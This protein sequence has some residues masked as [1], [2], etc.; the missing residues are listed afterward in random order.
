LTP[1]H[2]ASQLPRLGAYLMVL[3][4]MLRLWN[5]NRETFDPVVQELRQRAGP[6]LGEP[7]LRT[8]PAH[9]ADVLAEAMAFP[10]QATDEAEGKRRMQEYFEK[11]IEEKWVHKPLRSL[12]QVPPIDAAGHPGLRKKL[13]GVVQFLEDCAATIGSTYDFS[14]L[15]RK[16]G[17]TGAAAAAGSAA[18]A[19]APDIGAMNTAELAGLRIDSLADE[20]LENAF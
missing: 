5:C 20:Q 1:E 18:P 19:V 17:L 6:A 11:Y 16:L 8:G 7:Y 3:G 2:A 12:S 9:F 14:R 4:D 15:R 13:R 10:V